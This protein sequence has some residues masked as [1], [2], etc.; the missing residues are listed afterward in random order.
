MVAG[1]ETRGFGQASTIRSAQI[2]GLPRGLNSILTLIDVW[3]HLERFG[4]SA[5]IGNDF[6]GLLRGVELIVAIVGVFVM[7]DA[8]RT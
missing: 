1:L 5:T 3:F 2:C 8:C 6:W 7:L 4:K